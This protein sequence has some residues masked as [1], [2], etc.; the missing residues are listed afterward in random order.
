MN[1]KKHIVE[2]GLEMM[3]R[4]LTVET[5]GNISARDPETGLIYITPSGMDYDIITEDDIVVMNNKFKVVEGTRKPSI[6][7][8]IH[9]S[10]YN[11]RPDVNAVIHTHPIYSQVFACLHEPI[12]PVID[13]A[14][15]GFGG[16]VQCAEY[17]IPGTQELCDNVIS[18]LGSGMAVLLANHG[19]LTVGNDMKTAFKMCTIL[20][21]T[22]RI[23]QMAR[24]IGT[25]IVESDEVVKA[26]HDFALHHYGQGK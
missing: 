17:A 26:T 11:E 10:I 24:A 19:A 20:E 13:E 6:E 16:T 18:A 21:M 15:Q 1:Y 22:A 23:Y 5:W 8:R 4:K 14:A 3:K 12:P 25:P 9:I 7:Y 2:S